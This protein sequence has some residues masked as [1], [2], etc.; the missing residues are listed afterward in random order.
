M[1]SDKA[2]SWISE[3]S[4]DYLL[5]IVESDRNLNQYDLTKAPIDG[6]GNSA[7]PVAIDGPVFYAV[8]PAYWQKLKDEFRLLLCTKDKKYSTVR[9]ELGSAAKKSQTTIVS[10][11]AATMAT[12]FGVVAG[13]LVPFCALCLIAVSRL[14]KEAFCAAKELKIAP[15]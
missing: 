10:L 9:K 6:I 11:V 14:G 4:Y 8:W 1:K 2:E 5:Q 13:V 15:K 3:L 7:L 12:Q